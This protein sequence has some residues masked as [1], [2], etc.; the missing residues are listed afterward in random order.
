MA[1]FFSTL[2]GG[3]AERDAANRNRAA[4][5]DYSNNAF[6][7]FDRG[8]AGATDA[9][10]TGYGDA[11]RRL[12]ANYGLYGDLRGRGYDI[13]SNGLSEQVNALNGARGEFDALANLGTKYGGATTMLLN[14]L[15]V[16]GAG[17]NAAARDAFQA[18]PGYQWQLDQGNQAIN[19]R[20][21]AA[22]MLDSGNADID[23]INYGQGL[24]NQAYTGWQNTLAGFIN[25]ELSA[26]SGAATGRA[27]I[28]R[29][30]A[31]VYGADQNA[32]LGLE[33]GITQ[34][35][36]GVNT[37]RAANDVALA[38][39]LANLRTGDASN[40]VGVYG[41]VLSGNTSAN[42]MQA[43]GEASGARNLLGLGM[44]LANLAV[45]GAGGGSF[46]GLGQSNRTNTW[47][48]NPLSGAFS[49]GGT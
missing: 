7:A 2:F 15:G 27:G 12:D 37:A 49:F 44:N 5:G 8:L 18:G 20:R 6:A 34:G 25:P 4:I 11:G 46:G 17:G 19:R 16:N 1:S 43:Q 29:D 24:A 28:G 3:G 31:G 38:N 33:S 47:G 48:F 10:N 39:S 42:N 22:G 26:T 14:S 41:N 13:L 23:A 40:R 30:I 45:G 36:A 32:R 21:A 35:Q 9:L